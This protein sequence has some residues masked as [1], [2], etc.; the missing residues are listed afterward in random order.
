M[1]IGR[2]GRPGSRR[3][4]PS[5]AAAWRPAAS[6]ARR[7]SSSARNSS[8]V[9]RSTVCLTSLMVSAKR[10]RPAR[11]CSIWLCRTRRRRVRSARTRARTSWASWT[12]A[13]HSARA[14]ATNSSAS[15]LDASSLDVTSSWVRRRTSEATASAWAIR[16]EAFCSVRVWSCVASSC[17][18]GPQPGGIGFGLRHQVGGGVVGGAQHPGRLLAERGGERRLVEDRVGGTALG[19]GHGARAGPAPD[20]PPPGSREAICSRKTRTSAGSN[21]RRAVPKV[22]RATSSGC[23]RDDVEIVSR[24][25]SGM[26]QSLRPRHR[27]RDGFGRRRLRTM[28]TACQSL[29]TPCPPGP[30]GGPAAAAPEV[31]A[32]GARGP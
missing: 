27:P 17:G 4:V 1:D 13:R 9:I 16:S 12:M 11:S 23:R 18:L 10:S 14:W 5:W 15:S 30:G 6:A 24:R 29:G 25:S 20:R 26:G 8:S 31:T 21:P 32:E 3:R 28:V 2:R 19:L 7:A 22:W